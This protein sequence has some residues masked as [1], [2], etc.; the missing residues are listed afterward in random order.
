MTKFNNN[1]HRSL[2]KFYISIVLELDE[3]ERNELRKHWNYIRNWCKKN[4]ADIP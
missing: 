3:E 4:G 1:L 2:S